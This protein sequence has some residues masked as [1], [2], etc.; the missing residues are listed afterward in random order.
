MCRQE[1]EKQMAS[2]VFGN[3]VHTSQEKQSGLLLVVWV[4]VGGFYFF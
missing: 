1:F 3:A 4:L 2:N